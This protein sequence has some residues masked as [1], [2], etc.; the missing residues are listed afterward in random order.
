M[1]SG[2]ATSGRNLHR[3]TSLDRVH[4]QQ[5]PQ[6][7]AA[8][9]WSNTPR[10]SRS[11]NSSRT[12]KQ[13]RA[14]AATRSHGAAAL[15][16]A[17]TWGLCGTAIAGARSIVRVMDDTVPSS[18]GGQRLSALASCLQGGGDAPLPPPTPNPTPNPDGWWCPPSSR[19]TPAWEEPCCA[20]GQEGGG[21]PVIPC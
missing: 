12:R 17:A 4:S 8:A 19:A 9:A 7:S 3:H 5:Q 16:H 20:R 18:S 6:C 11:S 10:E 13:S 14:V 21:V 15:P 2:T 1:S